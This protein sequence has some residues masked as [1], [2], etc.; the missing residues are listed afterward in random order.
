MRWSIIS[1]PEKSDH[2]VSTQYYIHYMQKRGKYINV[3]LNVK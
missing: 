1:N 2:V 3:N